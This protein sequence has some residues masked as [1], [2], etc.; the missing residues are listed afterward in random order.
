MSI[1]LRCSALIENQV[2]ENTLSLAAGIIFLNANI[3]NFQWR[4]TAKYLNLLP[5]IPLQM[6]KRFLIN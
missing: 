6:I 5:F 2:S 4:F 1:C 3:S